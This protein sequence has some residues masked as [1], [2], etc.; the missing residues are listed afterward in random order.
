M[1]HFEYFYVIKIREFYTRVVVKTSII[2]Y[3]EDKPFMLSDEFHFGEYCNN[4]I[5][6][7][8]RKLVNLRLLLMIP[9]LHTYCYDLP[10]LFTE[11]PLP[12]LYY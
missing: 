9:V 8:Y 4:L 5:L 12:Y 11:L 10:F 6:I 2:F 1:L 7:T 3:D